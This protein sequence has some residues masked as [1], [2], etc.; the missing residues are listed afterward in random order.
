MKKLGLVNAYKQ[1]GILL[2][3]GAPTDPQIARAF[4]A[5]G[6][7]SWSASSRTTTPSSASS[8]RCCSSSTMNGQCAAGPLHDTG[9][10]RAVER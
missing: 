4:H 5:I 7:P 2:P 9:N 1:K 3:D 10:H 8:A 6:E